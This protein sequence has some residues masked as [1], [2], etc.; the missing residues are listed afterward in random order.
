MR[1]TPLGTTFAVDYAEI[2]LPLSSGDMAYLDL[3][4]ATRL[5][6]A[7]RVPVTLTS[8]TRDDRGQ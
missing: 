2:R 5:D 3:P 7:H 8:E 4:S 1:G 6:R